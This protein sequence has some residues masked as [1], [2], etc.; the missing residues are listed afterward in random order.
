MSIKVHRPSFRIPPKKKKISRLKSSKLHCCVVKFLLL[1]FF[2]FVFVSDTVVF[3]VSWLVWRVSV[4]I[5]N[6]FFLFDT[7]CHKFY[8]A[9]T[10]LAKALSSLAFCL[11]TINVTACLESHPNGKLPTKSLIVI[12]TM[13]LMLIRQ[14]RICVVVAGGGMRERDDFTMKPMTTHTTESPGLRSIRDMIISFCVVIQFVFSCEK[15]SA[16]CT[17]HVFLIWLF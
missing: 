15:A 5:L 11:V 3:M 13:C 14:H 7:R 12:W 10:L 17:V 4:L 8:G 9:P 16:K 2:I 1:F 6:L